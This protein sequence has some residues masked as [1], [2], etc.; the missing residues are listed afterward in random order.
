MSA[1][2]QAQ[3]DLWK[4][5]VGENWAALQGRLDVMLAEVTAE[6]IRRAGPVA[7]LRCGRI[8]PRSGPT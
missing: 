1:P 8:G 2:N 3:I 5:R 4:G 6:L 7:G